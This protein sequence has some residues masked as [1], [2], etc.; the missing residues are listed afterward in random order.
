MNDRDRGLLDHSLFGSVP[1][2]QPQSVFTAYPS[3]DNVRAGL[4]NKF[5]A[6]TD[7][8]WVALEKIHGANFALVCTSADPAV[9]VLLQ[10]RT[11]LLTPDEKFHG[12]A[13]APAIVELKPRVR[14]LFETLKPA[15]KLVVFGELFGSNIQREIFYGPAVQFACFDLCVDDRLLSYADVVEHCTQNA[16]PFIKALSSGPLADLVARHA[17]VEQLPSCYHPEAIAEGLVFRPLR[18]EYPL[19]ASNESRPIL[20]HKRAAFRERKHKKGQEEGIAPGLAEKACAFVTPERLVSVRSKM[21]QEAPFPEVA[22]A[23]AQ[24]AL[25]DVEKSAAAEKEEAGEEEGDANEWVAW[26]TAP[27]SA[28]KRVRKAVTDAAFALVKQQEQH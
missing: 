28:K 26:R 27:D 20:K 3:I 8:P 2:M 4:V 25:D 9:D 6:R 16:I 21:A 22:R 7:A 13:R 15:T 14:A 19:L 18:G 10:R 17:N 5:G 24:D 12:A 1:I 23:L 11:G